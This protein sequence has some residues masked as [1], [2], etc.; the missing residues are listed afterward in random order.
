MNIRAFE[1]KEF[2][3]LEND[4]KT[5]IVLI[6]SPSMFY[7]GNIK[8]E[9]KSYIP[10]NLSQTNNSFQI[11]FFDLFKIAIQLKHLNRMK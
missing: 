1:L 11:A 6:N 4:T 10:R 8:L 2:N 5:R 7:F 3:T 9:L